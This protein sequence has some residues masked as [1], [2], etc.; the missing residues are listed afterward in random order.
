V[1]FSPGE[2]VMVVYFLDNLRTQN[3]AHHMARDGFASGIRVT[4]GEM[5]AGEII[6]PDF[7]PFIDNCRRNIHP[8]FAA[9]GS[10]KISCRF[11]S[12]PARAKMHTDP[13]AIRLVGENIDVMIAAADG[14]ELFT[15]RRL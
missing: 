2:V 13:N 14:T 3:S 15:R 9:G 12:E 5:H 1:F 4:S 8:I 10:Q 7:G 11:V 6:A